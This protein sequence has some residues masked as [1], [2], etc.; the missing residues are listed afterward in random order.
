MPANETHKHAS[1]EA[2][3]TVYVNRNGIC[4]KNPVRKKTSKTEWLNG[5]EK[6]KKNVNEIAWIDILRA[7]FAGE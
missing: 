1:I 2:H 7:S 3:T 4:C 5:F 6:R